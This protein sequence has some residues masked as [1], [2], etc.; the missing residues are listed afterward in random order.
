VTSPP[1]R[2]LSPTRPAAPGAP[3]RE[4]LQRRE[5]SLRPAAARRRRSAALG[6]VQPCPSAR[7]ERG[8][9]LLLGPGSERERRVGIYAAQAAG[10]GAWL[11][12]CCGNGILVGKSFLWHLKDEGHRPEPRNPPATAATSWM[13]FSKLPKS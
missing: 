3:R 10:G 4:E 5:K 12:R 2:N 6:S 8:R 9:W 11:P 13:N 1:H 7:E